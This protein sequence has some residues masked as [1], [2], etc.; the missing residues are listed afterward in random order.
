MPKDIRNA[1]LTRLVKLRAQVSLPLINTS[2]STSGNN[3]AG[4]NERSKRAEGLRKK[5]S[6][7]SQLEKTHE[8]VPFSPPFTNGRAEVIYDV[9]RNKSTN[10]GESQTVEHLRGGAEV[11]LGHSGR[12]ASTAIPI[13][14]DEEIT[15]SGWVRKKR[16]LKS[17]IPSPSSTS[18]NLIDP[19]PPTQAIK[20]L[21]HFRVNLGNL[22]K[23]TQYQILMFTGGPVL[24]YSERERR[25][26]VSSTI[27]R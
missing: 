15:P 11:G 24:G 16:T 1:A 9:D 5:S 4:N 27:I 20:T 17:K 3:N 19:T 22:S 7:Q 10:G 6:S 14:D 21:N 23:H 2:L 25:K 18:R 8:S 26:V 12:S 13:E